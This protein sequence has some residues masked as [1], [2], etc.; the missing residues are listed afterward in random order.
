MTI[1]TKMSRI[2]KVFLPL[3]ESLTWSILLPVVLSHVAMEAILLRWEQYFAGFGGA[4][5]AG[6][7]SDSFCKNNK[8]Y[9][10]APND[11]AE[12]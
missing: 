12:G 9:V 3:L 6:I 1:I 10:S 7:D 4:R 11:V 8:T 2:V 5:L